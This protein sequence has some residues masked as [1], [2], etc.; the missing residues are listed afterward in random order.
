MSYEQTLRN[1]LKTEKKKK[2]KKKRK[3]NTDTGTL[4]DVIGAETLRKNV[5]QAFCEKQWDFPRFTKP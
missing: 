3:K 2:R 4:H 1:C 5:L